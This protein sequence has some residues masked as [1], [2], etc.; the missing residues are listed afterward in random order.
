MIVSRS[1][2]T[3]NCVDRAKK[4]PLDY[5]FDGKHINIIEFDK[6]L[7]VTLYDHKTR[8]AAGSLKLKP[9]DFEFVMPLGR[10]AFGKVVLVQ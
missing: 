1:Y 9:E 3:K 8:G 6:Q 5:A 7:T 4:T 2:Q 10:G